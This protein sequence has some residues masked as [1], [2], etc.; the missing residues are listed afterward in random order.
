MDI[1]K[2]VIIATGL[3]LCAG[4]AAADQG[5]RVENRLD[6]KGDRIEQRLD[7]RGDRIDRLLRQ[8]KEEEEAREPAGASS[9][10]GEGD[11]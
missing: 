8:V 5:D 6:R 7:N 2:S 10:D 4:T 3:L 9:G 1:R 11:K